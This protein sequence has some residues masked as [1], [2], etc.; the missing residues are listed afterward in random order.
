MFFRLVNLS[1]T[2][3]YGRIRHLQISLENIQNI[4]M[5]TTLV[6]I[7]VFLRRVIN[8]ILLKLP[9]KEVMASL[10]IYYHDIKRAKI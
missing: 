1:M 8:V 10:V 3:N 2:D 7:V 6:S 9:L 5:K 4:S